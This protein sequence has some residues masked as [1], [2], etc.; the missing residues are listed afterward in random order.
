[1]MAIFGTLGLGL[2]LSLSAQTGAEVKPTPLRKGHAK[3]IA[4]PDWARD[5]PPESTI[6]YR[7]DLRRRMAEGQVVRVRS[8]VRSFIPVALSSL[9]GDLSC[10]VHVPGTMV[11]IASPAKYK[12][13]Q[14]LVHHQPPPDAGSCWRA[15]GCKIEFDS[16]DRLLEAERVK[17][18]G[19]PLIYDQDLKNISLATPSTKTPSASKDAGR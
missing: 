3:A 4:K 6:D 7:R 18:A 10:A 19:V 11:E 1:M 12:G 17:L 9:S 14:L 15:P 13:L 8:V 2:L 16:Y 5:M